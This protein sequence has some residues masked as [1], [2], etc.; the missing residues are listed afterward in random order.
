[1][2]AGADGPVPEQ[3]IV[4]SGARAAPHTTDSLRIRS[5]YSRAARRRAACSRDSVSA[6]ATLRSASA[7]SVCSSRRWSA[8]LG[9]SRPKS[10][11]ESCAG[12]WPGVM[13]VGWPVTAAGVPAAASG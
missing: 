5:A 7:W 6:C 9:R 2:G 12:E 8:V 3:V 11:S 10:A 1:M 4:S 13:G